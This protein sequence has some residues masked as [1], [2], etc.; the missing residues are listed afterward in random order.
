MKSTFAKSFLVLFLIVIVITLTEII[1]RLSFPAFSSDSIY[2]ER[3]F[4]RLLNSDVRFD[5]NSDNY[6]KRFGFVLSPNAENTQTTKEFTYTSRTNSIGFRTKEMAPKNGDEY[7]IML[8]GD[9]FFWGVGV[10]ESEAISSV[11]EKLGKSKLSVYNFSVVG[12]NTVQEL[13]VAEA[14]LGSLKPDHI[15]LGFFIGNDIISN[16]VT[17]IDKNG[18]FN[19]SNTMELKIRSEL[20][21]SYGVLFHSVIFRIIALPVYIPRV[22]YKIAI[23]DYVIA[24]S[25]ERL[26]ELNKLARNNGARFSVVIF[27]PQDSVQG[28][29]VEAWSNSRK[30]GE[31][32]YSFCQNNSIEALDLIRY[33]NTREHKN[34]YFFVNDGHLNKEANYA[35]AKAILSDLVEPHIIH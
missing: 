12:Y 23:T 34:K 8:L 26:V 33:M 6:N 15:I 2:L 21:R 25:Y 19:T 28:G 18:N 11:M 30:A 3:A 24:K 9:S 32:I 31:L 27:Y 35:V 22:R 10:K 4:S 14:Y 13:L 16:A 29:M 1:V 7:R 17:L 20:R 5:P